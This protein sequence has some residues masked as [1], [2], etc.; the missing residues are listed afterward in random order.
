MNRLGLVDF[1]YYYNDEMSFEDGHMLLRGSNGSGKSVTMQSFIPLLLD[2]NKSSGRL[3]P[4]GSTARKMESY[5]LV[6]GDDRSDRIGYLWLEFKRE[7]SETYK[8]IGMGL[9]ARIGK[10]L[11][12]WYFVVEN[13]LRVNIDFSLLDQNDLTLTKLQLRN[14][15]GENCIY[16]TQ[17]EYMSKVNEALFGFKSIDDYKEVSNLLIQLRSPKL[18]NSLRPTVINELLSNALPGLDEDDLRPMSEAITNMDNIKDQLDRLAL[19]LDAAKRIHHAY[20]QYITS[21]LF[22]RFDVFRNADANLKEKMKRFKEIN[23]KIEQAHN[24]ITSNLD[25]LQTLQDEN[26]LLEKKKES[27]NAG[28][29]FALTKE[30]ESLKQTIQSENTTLQE[31]QK[32]SE[33]KQDRFYTNKQK[34]LKEEDT[35]SIKQQ[36]IQTILDTLD[37]LQQSI[38]FE[39]HVVFT[40]QLKDNLDIPYVYEDLLKL[41]QS[42]IHTL[43]NAIE[44][45]M[46]IEQV[47]NDISQQTSVLEQ[48]QFEIETMEKKCKDIEDEYQ[49]LVE[50]Y[51]SQ[52]T[53]INAQNKHLKLSRESLVQINDALYEYENTHAYH[54]ITTILSNA[55][56]SIYKT[57]LHQSI[58]TTN[59]LHQQNE[60]MET[61][62]HELRYWQTLKDP[63]PPLTP[64][65][66]EN[67]AMLSQQSIPFQ[68]LY[69]MLEFDD[70]I[71]DTL[72]NA[73]EEVLHHLGLLN[74]LCIEEIY[75]DTLA[76][77]IS[78][79]HDQYLFFTHK[80]ALQSYTICG[81]SLQEMI[82]SFT[83]YLKTLGIQEANT[84]HIQDAL[85]SSGLIQGTMDYSYVSTYIGKQARENYRL[86]QVSNFK[87]QLDI[88]QMQY[89][90]LLNKLEDCKNHLTQLEIEKE[91]FPHED[92]L[93][94]KMIEMEDSEHDLNRLYKDAKQKEDIISS[95][96]QRLQQLKAAFQPFLN[97]FDIP[98]NLEDFQKIK[99]EYGEYL[100]LVFDIRYAHQMYLS[101]FESA[102]FLKDTQ[103][104]L[105]SDLDSLQ[106]EIK[107]FTRSISI[108]HALLQQ[109]EELLLQTGDKDV[110]QQLTNIEQK[111]KDNDTNIGTLKENITKDKTSITY[112][113]EAKAEMQQS[114]DEEQL[115]LQASINNVNQLL[116]NPYFHFES[117][118]VYSC[119]KEIIDL[120]NQLKLTKDI[121][122]YMQIA[123]AILQENRGHLVDYSPMNHND[124]KDS[125][126]VILRFSARYKN[127][128]ISFQQLL[129]KLLED[130]EVQQTLL[131]DSDRQLFEEVLVDIL[132]KKV[133]GYIHDA[134]HWIATINQYMSKTDTSSNLKISLQW[135]PL[136]AETEDEL[137]TKK[138]VNILEKDTS[139]LKEEDLQNLSTHFRKK[140]E[141]ARMIASLD[142]T[143]T[144]SF[145][146]LMKEMMD[147]RT[148]YS[149]T[150]MT[151]KGNGPAKE[152]TNNQFLVYSGG[153]KAMCMYV[154]LFSAVAA[155]Y[156]DARND[157]PLIIALDEAFA[158]VD[159]KN[160]DAMFKLI[161]DFKFDYI[162]NSQV[163][164]GD[165]KY[166]NALAIYELIRNGSDPYINKI[167]YIWNGTVKKMML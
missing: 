41:L 72:K 70:S 151:S 89:E 124:E 17:K 92:A 139:I 166:V 29:A 9:R 3:D 76:T 142:S 68:P 117:T 141:R 66:E 60:I 30:I 100:S 32:D 120:K 122:E 83:Q 134:K 23:A 44:K 106:A 28:D 33:T 77:S 75:Q 43:E 123:Q 127:E 105:I 35:M 62:K 20:E 22:N 153:E 144:Q 64:S 25:L 86:Q 52:F 161:S 102:N 95:F 81:Q 80:D 16:E 130:I 24:Q 5:L 158:G 137:D 42:K 57:Y 87:E 2:G 74:A 147:Y 4:S 18:S 84:L 138:L 67:R 129:N 116:K 8:T 51:V 152:L 104:A 78:N 108:N 49:Q 71:S 40:S 157:C 145:H 125:L 13:N 136:K 47:K 79:K 150:I 118:D 19:S 31:K 162:M 107:A 93:K 126:G 163:L 113:E 97:E 114:L 45:L 143:N 36:Q 34:L 167:S 82:A 115:H 103:E 121:S 1:W 119:A 165:S 98:F 21:V 85:Y 91:A 38:L 46:K 133:R 96:L 59:Q 48:I 101:S 155:R 56:Q 159:T 7:N 94:E 65:M 54:Q 164:W 39:E 53:D 10:P 131:S 128:E 50:T 99:T 148:W 26:T 135:K 109:K 27:L 63:K 160:M 14:I 69:E 90:S 154:P 140:I 112:Y 132:S 6:E 58:E 146:Q 61:L 88:A 110:I 12:S 156:N 11:D 37:T 149:F 15:I 73:F 55:H 111:L